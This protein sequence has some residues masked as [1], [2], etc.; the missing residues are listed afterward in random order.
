VLSLLAVGLFVA[1]LA[2]GLLTKAPRDTIDTSLG[3]AEAAPA[4]GFDLPVLQRGQLGRPLGRRL[5]SALADG[6][7]SVQELRGNPVV[8]NFWASWCVPCRIEAPRLER[9]WKTARSRGVVFT[10]LNM[11]DV[12][13]DAGNFMASFGISYLNIRDK[14][15]DVAVDYGVTGIPETF[16]LSARG[17]VVAHVI[18]AISVQQLREGIAAAEKGRPLGA[19]QGGERRGTR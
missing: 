1:L 16:F 4:P 11:Q 10:G 13:E 12:N 14:S 17:K 2:Y 15:D 8:L 19:L 18:G 9:G 6:H 3:K 7:V 5:A